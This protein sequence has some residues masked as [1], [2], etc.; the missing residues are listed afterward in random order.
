M[1]CCSWSWDLITCC[2]CCWFVL[3]VTV[4]ESRKLEAV[5]RGGTQRLRKLLVYT[6][7]T[8]GIANLTHQAALRDSLTPDSVRMPVHVVVV[9]S[10]TTG[11]AV[12][13]KF[14]E[15]AKGNTHGARS[16]VVV[17]CDMAP[18]WGVTKEQFEFVKETASRLM[19]G[20]FVDRRPILCFLLHFPPEV[21]QLGAVA[22]TVP[23]SDWH[24]VSGSAPMGCAIPK[25]CAARY[26]SALPCPSSGMACGMLRCTR[27]PSA[28]TTRWRCRISTCSTSRMGKHRV[29]PQMQ[30]G[31]GPRR[32]K[33]C[34]WV[35]G[36][37]S[38]GGVVRM[39]FP[40]PPPPLP[41]LVLMSLFFL[42]TSLCQE[43]LL[44]HR[45]CLAKTWRV[46]PT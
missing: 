29:S 37:G 41:L 38:G 44:Q 18:G 23:S 4:Q 11:S 39:Y 43:S 5:A 31:M 3:L 10:F 26:F 21:A 7:T 6:R 12:E 20:V 30:A 45:L 22:S 25:L 42:P 13:T 16:L 14:Q 1:W 32:A 40:F 28:R 35:G 33:V 17:V 8:H 46:W 2:C 36:G 34:V 15:L 24:Y 9:T 27:T 19:D